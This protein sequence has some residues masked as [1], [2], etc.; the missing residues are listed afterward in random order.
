MLGRWIQ[1]NCR[2]IRKI[3]EIGAGSGYPLAYLAESSKSKGIGIEPSSHAIESWKKRKQMKTTDVELVKGVA[4]KLPFDDSSFDLVGFG[5]CLYLIDR[6]D[7]CQAIKEA[8]RV[9][10]IGGYMY[11]EDFDPITRYS[12]EYEH[13]KGIK[14]FKDN[15][16]KYM[17]NSGHYSIVRHAS[18]GFS[19]DRFNPRENERVSMTL[20]YKNKG[21]IEKSIELQT[22]HSDMIE[23]L[24][25]GPNETD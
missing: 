10:R 18:Y 16:Y 14:S 1:E 6:L 25:N 5:F 17:S 12:N 7:V 11:I 3:L 20:L 8:D 15:Y 21:N 24:D 2:D 13:K 9:L 23:N 22:L 19:S 4:N